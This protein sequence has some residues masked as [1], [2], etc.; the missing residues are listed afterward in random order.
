M[1]YAQGCTGRSRDFL[2]E[3]KGK[4]GAAS[5][6]GIQEKRSDSTKLV[7]GKATHRVIKIGKKGR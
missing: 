6:K 2:S 1:P 4:R 7:R 3:S 5:R